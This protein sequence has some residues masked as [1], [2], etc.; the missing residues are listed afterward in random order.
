MKGTSNN[1]GR[2]ILAIIAIMLWLSVPVSAQNIEFTR[3]NFPDRTGELKK[4]L[5]S[6]H[7]GDGYFGIGTRGSYGAALE[8][9]LE[10]NHFNPENAALNFKM[11]VCYLESYDKNMAL[12]CLEKAYALD[13]NVSK[14][15]RYYLGQAYQY[16]SRFSEALDCYRTYLATA[17]K[18]TLIDEAFIIDK[19]IRECESG[20]ALTTQK[21]IVQFDNLAGKINSIWDE[22]C[23]VID[24]KE[25]VMAFTSRRKSS[26]GER[27]NPMDGLYFEDIYFTY[28]DPSNV[29]DYPENPGKPLNG[30]TNDATVAISPDGNLLTVYK[31]IG[32]EDF[33]CES[34]KTDGLWSKPVKLDPEINV[35]RY[36]QPSATY[37]SDRNTIIYVSDKKGGCGGSDLYISQRR[38]NGSWGPSKS[39]GC[40]VNSSY[41]EEAPF[42]LDDS[43]LYF[44]S[45]GFNSIGGYD[46]F[47]SRLQPDGSWCEPVNMG[48][49]LNSPCDDLYMVLSPS[50]E[51]Y[52]S[53][54]RI[55][56]YGGFDI[57]HVVMNISVKDLF[58]RVKPV[59]ILGS[60]TDEKTHDAVSAMVDIHDSTRFNVVP[61]GVT[62][63][64][65]GFVAELSSMNTYDM[66]IQPVLCDS[67][68]LPANLVT[69]TVYQKG[70]QP[71]GKDSI[72]RTILKGLIRDY[73]TGK[74]L[75]FPIE[76]TDLKVNAVVAR[77]MPDSGGYFRF[78]LP[79]S[80]SYKVDVF[81]SA[82]GHKPVPALLPENYQTSMVDGMKIKLENVYFDF[83]RSEIRTDA[84][85]IL[86]RH[87]QLFNRFS[88]WKI[89]VAGHTD[90]MGSEDYNMYLSR[91]RA[92]SVADY[93][94]SRGVK[95]NQLKLVW[96]GYDQ[97]ATSNQSEE[98][99]QLNRRCEFTIYKY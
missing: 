84:S 16:Q 20:L 32:G 75:Q 8:Y 27:I 88:N 5:K 2:R 99:R 90:N 13:S 50:G 96:Y 36:H 95:K 71:A 51:Y 91:R 64:T 4:A 54:D 72:P 47:V 53:S 59:Y 29:W 67:L 39:L 76:V 23:P 24:A 63:S 62:D 7:K 26:V 18:K 80:A 11:G 92:Q 81:T 14:K 83:D 1:S 86:S 30:K 31:N 22:Y 43:T 52:L 35:N 12:S 6:Y 70:Y 41:D 40:I 15:I 21:N 66:L 38:S 87:A 61:G 98:G 9:Y 45:K 60:I 44:S 34:S 93:L 69:G 3:E 68:R 37:T 42:L 89:L 85:E 19:R 28:K 94:M 17:D 58:A 77:C 79:S 48:I 78:E 49:P 57:Y 10:A 97:P 74:P 55:N 56:G 73:K 82:C 25:S 33:I 46:V 65:G